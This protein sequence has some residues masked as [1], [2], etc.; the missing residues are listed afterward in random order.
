MISPLK[1]SIDAQIILKAPVIDSYHY[2]AHFAF[3]QLVASK[4]G[5]FQ[6]TLFSIVRSVIIKHIESLY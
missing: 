1:D 4:V 2:N 5:G 3:K 6:G